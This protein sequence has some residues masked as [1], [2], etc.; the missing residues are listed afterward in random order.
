LKVLRSWKNVNSNTVT[1]ITSYP[2]RG[3]CGYA[4]L[5]GRSYLVYIDRIDDGSLRTSIC[6]RTMLL[7][8]AQADLNALGRGKLWAAQ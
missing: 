6:S 4:F 8:N 1:V 3:G 7:E 5:V 2:S